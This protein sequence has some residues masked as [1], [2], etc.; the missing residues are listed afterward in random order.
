M[1]INPMI[2]FVLAVLFVDIQGASMGAGFTGGFTSSTTSTASTYHT[3]TEW[4]ARK[5]SF[6]VQVPAVPPCVVVDGSRINGESCI[7]GTDVCTSST[8]LLC[9]VTLMPKTKC[10]FGIVGSIDSSTMIMLPIKLPNALGLG[11][12]LP[13]KQLESAG[14][15]RTE[16]WRRLDACPAFTMYNVTIGEAFVDINVESCSMSAQVDVGNGEQLRVRGVDSLVHP[17]LDRGG[18]PG[19]SVFSRHFVLT[20]T[21]QMTLMNLELTGA[22]VGRDGLGWQCNYC[23]WVRSCLFLLSFFHSQC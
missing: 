18:V 14:L 19:A 7:C 13:S 10:S 15:Q 2:I 21:A 22:W 5:K 20:G 4:K 11:D 6:A 1:I 12:L 8:G 23:L 3:T 9:D 17:V 16:K